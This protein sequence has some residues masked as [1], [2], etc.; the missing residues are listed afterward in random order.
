MITIEDYDVAR[1]MYLNGNCI[2]IDSL[3]MT[4]LYNKYLLDFTG[5]VL[6]TGLGFGIAPHIVA[7]L[8]A[9]NSVTVVEL[10]GEVII[11]T[12][13]T[14]AKI[15]VVEADAWEWVPDMHFDYAFHDIH[16]D[17]TEQNLNLEESL[18]ARYS[19]SVTEQY[20]CISLYMKE[21]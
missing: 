21:H 15:R 17:V 6:M 1:H 12:P 4:E 13:T 16:M 5:D 14:S 3:I 18:K 8:P 10:V 20:G 19:D 11:A 2:A 7:S 9:V